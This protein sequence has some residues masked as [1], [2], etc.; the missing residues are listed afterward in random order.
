MEYEHSEPFAADEPGPLSVRSM[1]RAL[2]GMVAAI[3]LAVLVVLP[4]PYSIEGAGPTYN[5]LGQDSSGDPVLSVGGATTYPTSGQLRLTTVAIAYASSTPFSFGAAVRAWFDPS[6]ST[7]PATPI[8][9]NYDDAVSQEWLTSQDMA[10]VA[11]LGH[12]GIDVPATI[13]VAEIRSDSHAN[14]ALKVDDVIKTVDGKPADTMP[15]L[16]AAFDG[17]APGDPVTVVVSRG[18]KDVTATFDTVDN[19]SGRAVMGVWVDPTFDTPYTVKVAINNVGGPSAGLMFTL[20]IVD[21][22]TPQDELNGAKVAG[23]G[24]ISVNGDVGPIGGIAMK[25]I[26]ARRSGADYFLAPEADCSEVMGHVPAGLDVVSV[27]NLDEAYKAIVAIGKGQA[28]G[29]PTC[30]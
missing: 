22:L 9:A 19:G 14:G 7:Y 24:T 25:M 12:L 8:P 30:S 5:V 2:S 26:G 16:S 18:G 6:S 1:I 29:L 13:R 17:L 23:T 21:L 4:V 10:L 28:D 27:A 3:L 20:G 15:H 11:A